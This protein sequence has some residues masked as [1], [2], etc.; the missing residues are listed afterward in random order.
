MDYF[1][2][3]I[4]PWL[5]MSLLATSYLYAH[6]Q[7]LILK[8]KADS[9]GQRGLFSAIQCG[10]ANNFNFL[11]RLLMGGGFHCWVKFFT[12]FPLHFKYFVLLWEHCEYKSAIFRHKCYRIISSSEFNDCL[13]CMGE[14][15]SCS[16]TSEVDCNTGKS[17]A[18]SRSTRSLIMFRF[19][20][21]LY[22]ALNVN[23]TI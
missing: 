21:M 11:S 5:V 9:C 18:I 6:G 3:F 2:F 23:I 20:G 13:P 16:K 7:I 8:V 10:F 1:F 17:R 4:C 19:S 12:I 15:L 14:Y 22:K